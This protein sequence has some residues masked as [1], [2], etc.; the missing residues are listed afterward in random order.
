M[1]AALGMGSLDPKQGHKNG[2]FTTMLKRKLRLELWPECISPICAWGQ[3]MDLFGDHGWSCNKHC[4]T[5]IHNSIRNGLQG[6]FKVSSIWS[7]LPV[8]KKILYENGQVLSM[9]HSRLDLSIYEVYLTTPSM[10]GHGEPTSQNL[11]LMS[12]LSHPNL[13]TLPKQGGCSLEWNQSLWTGLPVG[14]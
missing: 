8:L 6:L 7:N 11:D 4:K 9:L 14:N 1:S 12:L 2:D 10:R 5:A 3:R 13:L